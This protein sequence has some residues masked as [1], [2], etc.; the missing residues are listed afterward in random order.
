VSALPAAGLI[1]ELVLDDGYVL[2]LADR[3]ERV[4]GI[5]FGRRAASFPICWRA[6]PL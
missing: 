5:L 3:R 1:A 6:V 4:A 2:D